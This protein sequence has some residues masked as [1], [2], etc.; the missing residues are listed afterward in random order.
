VLSIG[1]AGGRRIVS[2]TGHR[3]SK[4]GRRLSLF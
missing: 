2:G 4:N 1:K 3:G